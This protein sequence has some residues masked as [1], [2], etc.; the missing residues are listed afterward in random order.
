[1]IALH[2]FLGRPEDWR[3]VGGKSW[4]APSLWEGLSRLAFRSGINA[5]EAWA[6]DFMARENARENSEPSLLLGYSLGGRLAMHAAIARPDLFRALILVSVNPG[7]ARREERE[8][9]LAHDQIWADRFR[10]EPWA[11]VLAKWNGQAVLAPPP[12]PAGNFISL[13]REEGDFDRELLARSLTAWSLGAQDDLRERLRNLPIPVLLLS[14]E[15]DSKFTAL[16]AGLAF[17]SRIQHQIIQQ[18]G[19]RVPWDNPKAFLQ[20][21]QKFSQSLA[22]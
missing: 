14:G 20:A 10:S 4:T 11:D 22:P 6:D 16:Q 13:Q 8:A 2:G 9:R 12:K 15:H 3:L 21:V 19:H 7:L 17:G 18:A 5:F 1:L